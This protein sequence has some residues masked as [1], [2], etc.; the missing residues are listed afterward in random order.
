MLSN[1]GVTTLNHVGKT[2][3]G[4]NDMFNICKSYD[5]HMETENENEIPHVRD[6]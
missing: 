5:S 2:D 4:V 6:I 1:K 3:P